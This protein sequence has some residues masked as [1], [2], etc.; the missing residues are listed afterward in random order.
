MKAE[1]FLKSL[2]SATA[3]SAATQLVLNRY[4]LDE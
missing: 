3:P 2:F 4:Q 1:I